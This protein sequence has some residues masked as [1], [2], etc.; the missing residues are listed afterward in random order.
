MRASD[1]PPPP[2]TLQSVFNLINLPPTMSLNWKVSEETPETL[3]NI[4]YRNKTNH[5]DVT[6]MMHPVLHRLIF[7]TMS[8]NTDLCEKKEDV[9]KRL[10]YINAVQPSLSTIKWGD[11]ISQYEIWNGT[12]WVDLV[13]HLC[14]KPLYSEKGINGYSMIIN[15]EWIDNYWGLWTNADRKNFASWFTNFNKRTLEMLMHGRI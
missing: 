3:V 11:E 9:K 6:E 10:K 5:E 15:S 14:L 8:L 12:E 2:P 7:L 4:K 13:N 1:D